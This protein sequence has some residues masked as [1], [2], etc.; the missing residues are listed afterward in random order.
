MKS[1]LVILALLLPL[2]AH[3]GKWNLF[4]STT[5]Q[6]NGL[7]AGEWA[8]FD[9]VTADVDPV[10][11]NLGSCENFDVFYYVDVDG[12]TTDSSSTVALYTCP[13]DTSSTDA[14]QPL[15]A[16]TGTTMSAT[17]TEVFGASAIW[18]FADVSAFNED[19]RIIV[20]CAQPSQR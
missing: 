1:F 6:V 2:T 16:G 17:V 3:A 11:L 5:R 14:C 12:S 18:L 10:P 15:N 9:P 19:A 13:G 4:G 8:S 7:Q 20:K